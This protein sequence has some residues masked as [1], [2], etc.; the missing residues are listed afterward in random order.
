MPAIIISLQ[1]RRNKKALTRLMSDGKPRDAQ[2][3]A[4]VAGEGMQES[5]DTM[6][7]EGKLIRTTWQGRIIYTARWATLAA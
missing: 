5:I 6:F 3:I 7:A 1:L 2:D 4:L